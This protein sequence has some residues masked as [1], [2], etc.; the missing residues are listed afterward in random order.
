MGGAFG[1]CHALD[2]GLVFGDLSA[3]LSALLIGEQSPAEAVALSQWMC[4]AWTAFAING[5]PG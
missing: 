2:I 5:T 3:G 4:S 1:A